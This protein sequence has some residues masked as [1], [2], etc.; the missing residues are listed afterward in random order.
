[1][2]SLDG[3]LQPGT[4]TALMG[5]SGS[6]K[7]TLIDVLTG[8]KTPSAGDVLY[9]GRAPTKQFLSHG[10][11]YAAQEESLIENMTAKEVMYYSY[12]LE[13]GGRSDKREAARVINDIVGRLGIDSCFDTLVGGPLRKGLSGGQKK[14]LSI[15]VAILGRPEFLVLDEPTSGLDS[16][17]SL[18][19]MVALTRLSHGGLTVLSSIHSPSPNVFM[20]F[21]RLIMLLD[22]SMVFFGEVGTGE[23]VEYFGRLGFYKAL[24]WEND[25]DWLSQVVSE[26]MR[27]NCACCGDW[28]SDMVVEPAVGCQCC[29]TFSGCRTLVELYRE[30]DLRTE[31][32]RQLE[33]VS[34]RFED[35][36]GDN[37]VVSEG[38]GQPL[39]KR[40]GLWPAW[41]IMKHR[42]VADYREPFFTVPRIGEKLIFAFVIVT[43]Y[44]NFG[45][46]LDALLGDDQVG[47]DNP[48]VLS[49]RLGLATCVFMWG[50]LP[51]FGQLA[52]IPSLFTERALY[53]RES[54]AGY[55]SAGP[56]LLSRVLEE[57]LLIA[58]VSM[59]TAVAVYYGVGLNPSYWLFWLT[60]LFTSVCG[61]LLAY[62]FAAVRFIRLLVPLLARQHH[63]CSPVLPNS[64]D[65]M[66][67]SPTADFALIFDAGFN[68]ILLFFTGFLI[69]KSEF[70]AYW[71]W[72]MYINYMYYAWGALMKNQFALDPET[73]G[74]NQAIN[75]RLV[76]EF[77][78]LDDGA[79]GWGYLGYLAIFVG[80]FFVIGFLSLK[81]VTRLYIKR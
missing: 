57:V 62:A 45:R 66:Q 50:V 32:L 43:I 78:G 26:S 1:L 42:F 3:Y 10:I 72:A 8:R 34:A 19:V 49:Y 60:H 53:Q 74:V 54:G 13:R 48:Q 21:N 73:Y 31:N 15:A 11:A 30:S 47:L 56:F 40:L 52:T 63:A 79:S 81:F 16:Q 75:G 25:A 17:T 58:V 27:L 14:R 80:A 37:T 68:I 22:G 9:N 20:L 24:E 12:D 51:V 33:A 2:D 38:Y 23:H 36:N 39:L 76:L 71:E 46:D 6:G 28:K 44:L 55:Y 77:Y 65:P 5:P 67:A 59:I 7:T 35:S 4:I 69:R 70:P 41:A 64:H 61:V 29:G 18:E